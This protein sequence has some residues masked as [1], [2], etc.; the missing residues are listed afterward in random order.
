MKVTIETGARTKYPDDVESGQ[1][2]V[3]SG[4]YF[5]RSDDGFIDLEDG[6]PWILNDTDT[7]EIFNLTGIT[8]R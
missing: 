4:K 8:L 7:G 6:T 5:F 3:H 2:F 1:V